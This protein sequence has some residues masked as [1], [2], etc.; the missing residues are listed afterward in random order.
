MRQAHRP[1]SSSPMGQGTVPEEN[2]IS[3]LCDASRGRGRPT[4]HVGASFEQLGVR[5]PSIAVSPLAK[6]RYLS[7]TVGD[8]TSSLVF[9]EKRF[10]RSSGGTSRLTRRDAPA[11]TLEELF[12]FDAHAVP[13]AL[14]GAG[15]LGRE[16][17]HPHARGH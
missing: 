16:H 7:Q 15:R 4:V 1:S 12:D 9:I 13:F 17:H 5:V 10:L 6:P 8:H 2:A 11:H 14:L 3:R